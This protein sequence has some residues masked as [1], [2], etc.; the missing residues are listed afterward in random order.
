MYSKKNKISRADFI[1][2]SGAVLGGVVTL[3]HYACSGDFRSLKELMIE[4]KTAYN[5]VIPK[6]ANPKETNAALKLQ[7]YLSKVSQSL[8]VLN[9]EEYNG[10]HGIYIGNTAF[11]KAAGLG[12]TALEEDAYLFQ[13]LDNNL[14]IAGGVE[15]GLLNG[16]YS[17]LEFFGFRKYSPD[18]PL[19]LPTTN[20]FSFPKDELKTPRIKYRTTNYY[21][22]RDADYE[23]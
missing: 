4:G 8:E 7:S 3:S 20:A 15:N 10:E 9:E 12:S 16:V 6:Q 11:A 19:L 18:D 2:T 22:A 23:S 13:R 17:L 5:I 14:I 1:K 21:D